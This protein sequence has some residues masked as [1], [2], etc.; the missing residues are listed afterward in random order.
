MTSS[1]S[2][3]TTS[4]VEGDLNKLENTKKNRYPESVSQMLKLK[5]SLN[6]AVFQR[7]NDKVDDAQLNEVSSKI[8]ELTNFFEKLLEESGYVKPAYNRHRNYYYR[9]RPNK[10]ENN[11]NP[12]NNTEQGPAKSDGT[13]NNNK[14]NIPPEK[15]SKKKRYNKNHNKRNKEKNLENQSNIKE[16]E[17]SKGEADNSSKEIGSSAV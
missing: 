5:T 3:D 12:D 2:K 1:E 10:K 6:G 16:S 13:G 4:L 14:E 15:K 11:K 8:L 9:R 17:E 7:L